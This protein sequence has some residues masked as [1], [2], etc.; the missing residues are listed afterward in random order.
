MLEKVSAKLSR[1]N[2]LLPELSYRGRVLVINNLAASM[3]WHKLNVLEPPNEMIKVLQR[4]FVNF[5]WSGQHWLPGSVLYLP[6]QEGG[7][8]LIDVRSRINTF[9]LQTAQ[10]ILYEEDQGWICVACALLRTVS[11]LGYDKQLFLLKLKELD[12]NNVSLFY[13][14]ML[15][16]WQNNFNV[17]RDLSHPSDWIMGEPLLYNPLIQTRTLS[18]E[19]LINCLSRAGLTKIGNLRETKGWKTAATL[20]CESG[21]RSLRLLQQV[22]EEVQNALSGSCREA[23]E[24]QPSQDWEKKYQFPSISI[25]AAAEENDEDAD[26]ILSFKTPEMGQFCEAC[27]KAIYITC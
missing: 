6:L 20:Q 23:L 27:K 1:W 17:N 26:T 21:I 2:W 19:S 13:Q 15:K 9:R 4:R 12:L 16:A 18:S 10:R 3:L 25:S 11:G 7:Q 14:S 5:F 24:I 8:A 22:I